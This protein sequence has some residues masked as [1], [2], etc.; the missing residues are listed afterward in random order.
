MIS[1]QFLR[2]AVSRIREIF[3]LGG[4]PGLLHKIRYF[5]RRHHFMPPPFYC[6]SRGASTAAAKASRNVTEASERSLPL[7]ALVFSHNLN[8][9]GASI[10]LFELMSA[11]KTRGVLSPTLVSYQ[12]G[13]V[14]GDYEAVGIPVV[15]L[16]PVLERLSTARRLEVV[17][18][19]MTSL[20]QS[21]SAELVFAN[22]L[23]TFP[24]I[25]AAAK[26]GVPSVWNPRE[27]ENWGSYFEF[28]PD[29]VAQQAIAAIWLPYRTVFVAHATRRVWDALDTQGNFAVVHNGVDIKRFPSSQ[30][31]A[32]R[33]RRRSE[34]GLEAE[35]ITILC[36]GTVCER[37]GQADL[38]EALLSLPDACS[39]KVQ[40]VLLGDDSN[41]YA[42]NFKAK[43]KS[44]L[45]ADCR[46]IRFLPPTA[47]VADF[48]AAADLFV[49]SSRSESF[50]RVVLEA[51]VFGLPIIS[52]P[53]F[54]VLEQVVEGENAFFYSP[55]DC[56]A[57]SKH[58]ERLVSD[59]A[60][61]VRMGRSSQQRSLQMTTYD[62]MVGSYARIC[63]EAVDRLRELSITKGVE[64]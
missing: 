50:P 21:Y 57:L 17:V 55:G 43:C 23:L 18:G 35:T 5:L 27:S 26:A 29:V 6:L 28:L 52:T 30:D 60:L 48:Y 59:E 32:E 39:S 61:R 12:D 22:T 47:A 45:G 4:W 25:L 44:L 51:M 20:L 58:I 42:K 9:E 40:I 8:R 64:R 2:G 46:Q 7:R 38:L 49:L 63:S 16:P 15:L 53:V 62:E 13:P 24:A 41:S 1:W 10:S 14:R 11:L 56:R 34:L 37:K 3:L 19:E 36:V 31:V 54:G 33:G